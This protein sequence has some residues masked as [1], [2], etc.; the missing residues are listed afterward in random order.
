M[1]SQSFAAE[2]VQARLDNKKENILID[3]SYGGGCGK[4]DF[5]LKLEGCMESYP[6]QCMAKLVHVSQDN[7]EAMI[8]ET[9]AIPLS[10]Y[11]LLGNY[12]KK[13]SLT[14]QGDIS[15][16]TQKASQATVILP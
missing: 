14:I 6:V 8:F 5:S 3:V 13:G 12:Y 2:V 4:H 15:W 9:I 7:C 10:A 11:G 16:K 1:A